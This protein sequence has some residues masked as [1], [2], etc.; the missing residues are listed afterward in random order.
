MYTRTRKTLI[1]GG[2]YVEV[3]GSDGRK[4]S[5]K[6]LENHVVEEGKEHDEIGL[7]GSDFF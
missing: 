2:K 7:R 1:R 3:S 4:V 6:A 5:L